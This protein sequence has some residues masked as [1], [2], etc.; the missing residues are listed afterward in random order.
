MRAMWPR[1]RRVE[2][3]LASDAGDDATAAL[4]V[5]LRY[6]G[7]R[8]ALDEVRGA[9]YEGRVGPPTA[10]HLVEAAER[11]RLRTRGLMVQDPRQIARLPTPNIAHVTWE[12]GTLPRA[13]AGDLEGYFS[14]VVS[15]S[16]HRVRWIHPYSAQRDQELAEFCEYA[17]GIFLVFD[18]AA[19]LP[20]AKLWPIA[21]DE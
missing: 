2:V 19:D 7:R 21:D 14:V 17:S 16:P 13:S 1:R 6:R 15:V 18:E 12:R 3:V 8:V 5:I 11:Y 10:A 9:I 20:R 4:A